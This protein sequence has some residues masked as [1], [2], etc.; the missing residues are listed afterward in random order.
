MK[1]TVNEYDFRR[2]FETLRPEQFSYE[3]L[4]LLYQYFVELEDDLGEEIELDVIAI[5]CEWSED[6]PAEIMDKYNLGL[7]DI[8]LD[9]DDDPDKSAIENALVEYL[10]DRTQVA[11]STLA[12]SIVYM[13]Y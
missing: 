7:D 2:A 8:G 11:G 3:G 9:P 1:Q 4:G 12:P 10:N 5:C 6:S 13:S